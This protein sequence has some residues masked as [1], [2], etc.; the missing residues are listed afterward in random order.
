MSS[1]C[2]YLYPLC[3]CAESTM[4]S[5]TMHQLALLSSLTLRLRMENCPPVNQETSLQCLNSKISTLP[6]ELQ[7]HHCKHATRAV[8][9]WSITC[10]FAGWA[11]CT[12]LAE[13][14]RHITGPITAYKLAILDRLNNKSLHKIKVHLRDKGKQMKC[15]MTIISS[16]IPAAARKSVMVITKPEAGSNEHSEKKLFWLPI[17]LQQ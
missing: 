10:M 6:T 17:I 8:T 1:T 13:D 5:E 3:H 7:A 11:K 4:H 9:A 15:K 12:D 16:I 14:I 2:I